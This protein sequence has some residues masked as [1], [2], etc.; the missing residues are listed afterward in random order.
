M[1]DHPPRLRRARPVVGTSIGPCKNWIRTT[2][3]RIRHD[4][5]K[6][7]P[8]L[9]PGLDPGVHRFAEKIMRPNEKESRIDSI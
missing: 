2:G 1:G 8:G 7:C 4:P 3:P 5:A 6:A 9:D